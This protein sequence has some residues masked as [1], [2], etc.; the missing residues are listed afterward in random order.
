MGG[1]AAWSPSPEGGVRARGVRKGG[2]T[3]G[4]G[5][6]GSLQIVSE[7]MQKG[8]PARV[9]NRNGVCGL[10]S[11]FSSSSGPLASGLSWWGSWLCGNREP[12]MREGVVGMLAH[13][14]TFSLSLIF[15]LSP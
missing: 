3:A 10:S 4:P 2:D 5:P 9:Q 8:P 12:D 1:L 14:H 6:P 7:E 15:S 11:D 13:S